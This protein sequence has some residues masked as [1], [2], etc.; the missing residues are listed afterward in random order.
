MI[1]FNKPYLSGK[2]MACIKN[3]LHIGKKMLY[4]Q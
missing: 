2:E 3:V 4:L 1:P